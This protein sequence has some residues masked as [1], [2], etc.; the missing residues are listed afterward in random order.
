MDLV[1]LRR[2]E[3]LYLAQFKQETLPPY[4]LTRGPRIRGRR[5]YIGLVTTE[6][7]QYLLT[8]PLGS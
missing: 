8:I 5:I 6:S 1:T 3:H 7:P 2:G 4:V